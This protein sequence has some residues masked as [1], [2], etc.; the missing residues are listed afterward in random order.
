MKL[1]SLLFLVT[2]LFCCLGVRAVGKVVFKAQFDSQPTDPTAVGFYQ[3]VN[4]EEGDTR[5][6][7]DGVLN[8]FNSDGT[9]DANSWW[10]RAIKF[11]NL[12]LVE[13]KTYRLDFK[14]QGS[15][16]YEDGEHEGDDRPRCQASAALMQGED[17][18]DI[19]LL[20]YDGNEQRATFDRFN[21]NAYES[22]SANFVF[23]S[24][25][26][27]KTK[28]A[29]K[30]KGDLADKFFLTLN[31]FNPG[32][33]YVKD[34]VLSEVGAVQS[35]EFGDLG[36]IK[37]DFGKN[38]NI[39]DMAKAAPKGLV[40]FGD[41]D[42]QYAT[43]KVNGTDA[44]VE[45]V[46]YHDDGCLYIFLVNQVEAT[47]NVVINF[48]NPTDNKQI[49]YTDREVEASTFDIVD[50]DA[51]YNAELAGE[52]SFLYQT[53]KLV[54]S[55]PANRSFAIDKD[56]SEFTLT[57]D[58]EVLTSK[59]TA[60][61]DRGGEII[62]LNLKEGTPATAEEVVFVRTDNGLL[63]KNNKISVKNV[64]TEY[65]DY[66]AD[67]DITFEAG[68][69]QVAQEIYTPVQTLSFSDAAANSIPLGWTLYLN[70]VSDDEK[71]EVRASGSTHGSGPR[72]LFADGFYVRAEGGKQSRA[73]FGDL[74]GYAVTLPVGDLRIQFL[75]SGYKAAGQK[76][77]CEVLDATGQ[78]VLASTETKMET[79]TP[80]GGPVK[81]E[82]IQKVTVAYKNETEQ[83]A[84]L[85]YTV[86]SGGGM[87]ETI[88]T[89]VVVNTYEVTEGDVPNDKIILADPSFGGAGNNRSP[90]AESG[91]E[92]WQAGEMRAFDTDFNYNGTRI[93]NDL[94]LKGLKIGY[95]CNGQW[96]NG[97]MAYGA[98][99]GEGAPKLA[100]PQATLDF[101]LYAANWKADE[102]REIHIQVLDEAGERVFVNKTFQTSPVNMN[103][104]RG[105][106]Y[107][108]DKFTFSWDCPEDG[109]YIVKFGSPAGETLIGNFSII[110]PGSRAVKYYSQLAAAVTSAKETLAKCEDA[111]YDGTTKNNLTAA[112]AK[113]EDPEKITMTTEE[114]F[115]AAIAE[116]NNLSKALVTR[117]EYVAR[118][119][120]AVVKA[121]QLCD[122][123]I[124]TKY[125]KLD[126]YVALAE[127]L[128]IY[129]DVDPTTLED[130]DLIEGTTKLEAANTLFENMKNAIDEALT[131]QIVKAAA[132]LVELDETM[133]NDEYVV[134]AG[135]AFTDDQEIANQLKL[136]ITKA[137]YDKC[138]DADPFN[139]PIPDP[140]TGEPTPY[141]KEDS[142]ETTSYVQNSIIYVAGLKSTNR[143]MG[144]TD[145]L[146]GWNVNLISGNKP[147]YQFSWEPWPGSPQ[148]SIIHTFQGTYGTD[149]VHL[150]VDN[151][152]VEISQ[153]LS[154][155][156]VGKF[157]LVVDTQDRGF[158]T[159]NAEKTAALE[160]KPHW[161]VIGD[162]DGSGNKKEGEIFSYIFTQVGEAA[163]VMTGFN[164]EKQGQWYG[165]TPCNSDIFSVGDD[166]EYTGSAN[167]GVHM[168]TFG[169]AASITDVKIFMVGKAENYDYRDAAA[170]L[171]EKITAIETVQQSNEPAEAP[172]KVVYYD[173]NGVATSAPQG[174]AI[175]V[176]TYANGY[177]K[178]TKVVVK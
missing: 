45:A 168:L 128:D 101:T 48:T 22:Y 112:I 58:H 49:K 133:V 117:G 65:T 91:W 177:V 1:K 169:G 143:E 82:N 96:P 10:R 81:D 135:N 88:L 86:F 114:E 61:L 11:R 59:I 122:G 165:Y 130:E 73:F 166:G 175:K 138:T 152:E 63:A 95:Y 5:S 125:E 74:E 26:M 144:T 124:G 66:A 98:A 84:I 139:V 83:N 56:L 85:R 24:E 151:R 119:N 13:G 159:D 54:A 150:I 72:M 156:P 171:Q 163:P 40:I 142:I 136:R 17:D 93:F 145:E 68:K 2:L 29:E 174:I 123:A 121:N 51:A 162:T 104:N 39:A 154:F 76:V 103:G 167:V 47:D 67:F 109:N 4:E 116:L 33:F 75:A 161:T 170:K 55:Y 129:N 100:L 28:Y 6:V 153:A 79:V 70:Y 157:R 146:V 32:S 89:G 77:L 105:A 164:I 36:A 60:T 160:T 44:D 107:E 94:G 43:A 90:K 57:F 172:V 134:A 34:L 30:G 27:Q 25:E 31:I 52:M 53:P 80:N 106:S 102:S 111:I 178:V 127:V 158:N 15:N 38:T 118:F 92:L 120:E 69:P 35:V 132:K 87:D 7:S 64:L 97:Y 173:L 23:A 115:N 14:L 50:F 71:G 131:Y 3:F 42:I 12:P 110:Q 176:A 126:S 148:R 41:N 8:F 99:H 37:V 141:T 137:I 18:A 140:E 20:D 113:Y 62:P 108:A 16:R 147:S 21:E 155:L 78:N 46:E 19:A 9:L 149:Q